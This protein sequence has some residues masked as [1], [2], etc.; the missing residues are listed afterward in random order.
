M[1]KKLN[2]YDRKRLLEKQQSG[3]SRTNLKR[4]FSI[5]DNRTLDRQLK[6]A[7]QE[8]QVWIVK[9]EIIKDAL[10]SHLREVSTIIG[11]WK[12]SISTPIVNSVYYDMPL[13]PTQDIENNPLFGSLREHLPFPTFWRDYATWKNK[14]RAYI[15]GCQKIMKEIGEAEKP[16][17]SEDIYKEWGTESTSK[18]LGLSEPFNRMM[19]R[20]KKVVETNLGLKSLSEQLTSVETKLYMNLQEIQLRRDHIMYTCRLCPGQSRLSI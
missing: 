11:E 9:S 12:S 5:I 10:V 13:I 8:E 1:T 15:E 19:G 18:A 3:A 16:S 7:M 2:Q 6:L 4:M 20:Y 17:M 14:V